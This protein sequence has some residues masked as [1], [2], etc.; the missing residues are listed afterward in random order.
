MP[1]LVN[2]QLVTDDRIRAEEAR[3]ARHPKWRDIPDEATRAKR[4]RAEAEFSAID[5]LLVEQIASSDPRPVDPVQIEHHLRTQKAMGN[6]RN[7]HDDRQVRAQVER[8]LR[9]QRTVGEMSSR[10]PKPTPAAVEAFYHA[11]RDNFRGCAAF[12]ASHIVKHVNGQQS[13]EKARTGIEAAQADLEGGATFAEAADRHSDCKD[14][15]GDLGEFLAGTMVQEFE[16]AIREL[17]PGERTGIFRTPFGF[18]IAELR[19]KTPAGMMGFEE[20][21]EDIEQV[22]TKIAEHQE[23]LR[24]VGHVRAHADIRWIPEEGAPKQNSEPGGA[25]VSS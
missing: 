25:A 4:I 18:H 6:G 10:S 2:G 1:Y 20:V 14:K 8:S 17:K 9:L 16:D 24:V 5:A 15:S 13:E 22:L 11:H 23:F 12:Q 21:R 3:T 7:T 19:H